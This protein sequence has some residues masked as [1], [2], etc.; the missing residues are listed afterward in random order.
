[1]ARWAKWL[2]I[3]V[4][5]IILILVAL[6]IGLWF[7]FTA[8]SKPS[9]IANFQPTSFQAKAD[10]KVFYSIGNDLKYSDQIDPEAPT[11]L[12]G[13]IKN[14]LVS[15]DSK[16][17]AVVANGQLVIV[18]MGSLRQITSVDSIYRE[19]KPIGRQFFRDDDFQWSKD[20]KVLYLIRDEYYES[21][22]SQ[23][24]SSKGELWKYDIEAASLQLVL[25]PFS[26]Y[27]Y[28]FGLRSG[29]YF[30]IPTDRGDLILRYFDGE[31]VKDIGE[32]NAWD[33]PRDKLALDSSDSPFYSFSIHDYAQRV[34]SS[35]GVDLALAG[36]DGPE[37]LLING[38]PYLV[39][40]QGQNIKG[41][42][43]FRFSYSVEMRTASGARA[44][45]TL[46]SS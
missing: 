32:S 34:L 7:S 4:G 37:R 23:L 9:N 43:S 31:H 28:F 14:F 2:A 20:S 33:I 6:Y 16:K 17:I 39:L 12:R 24:F 15:P 42:G 21:Q 22:G 25:K 26:A 44:L 19:P 46:L 35:K 5:A 40:T 27:S 8:N 3:G 36:K 18:G 45:T 30:S 41:C 29:I 13:Q 10:A 11:L 1:M 38:K